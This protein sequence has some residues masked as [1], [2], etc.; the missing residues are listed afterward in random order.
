MAL[1]GERAEPEST[2]RRKPKQTGKHLKAKCICFLQEQEGGGKSHRKRAFFSP[3]AKWEASRCQSI[4]LL[5]QAF[6]VALPVPTVVGMLSPPLPNHAMGTRDGEG[7]VP[8]SQ[9][10][11]GSWWDCAMGW[12]VLLPM[13]SS[14]EMPT[15]GTGCLS[16]VMN[17]GCVGVCVC[18][19]W[20]MHESSLEIGTDRPSRW[21]SAS[22]GHCP[23]CLCPRHK[24]G[25][26]N[27]RKG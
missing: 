25:L 26:R 23:S 11:R 3:N 10:D 2:A 24:A 27:G 18:A 12:V 13:P 21:L 7:N 22:S 16:T 9:W 6:Q 8:S 19:L 14:A 4:C 1:A 15:C 5:P 20:G 17:G